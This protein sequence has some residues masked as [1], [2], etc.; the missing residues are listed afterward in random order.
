MPGIWMSM[1]STSGRS[2]SNSATAASPSQPSPATA[3][4]GSAARMV[5]SDVVTN[6]S[7]STMH[8]R[9]RPSCAAD[10]PA[11]FSSLMGYPPSV[12]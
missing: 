7:S 3:T 12:R 1:S 10:G 5:A 8:T 6:G 2:R 9:M 11:A 4:S